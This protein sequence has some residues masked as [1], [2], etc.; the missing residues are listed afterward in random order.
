MLAQALKVELLV[1][2]IEIAHRLPAP[3]ANRKRG[4]PPPVIV[5]FDSRRKRG[6]DVSSDLFRI[7]LQAS[8][9]TDQSIRENSKYD[10]RNRWL[11][12]RDQPETFTL[13]YPRIWRDYHPLHVTDQLLMT[14]WR[15]QDRLGYGEFEYLELVL[16]QRL[17]LLRM[18]FS[19]CQFNVKDELTYQLEIAALARKDGWPQV[20]RNC[21]A[22]LA[23]FSFDKPPC[24]VLEEA[25]LHWAK[26]NREVAT[27]LLKSLLRRLEQDTRG[28]EEQ[29]VQ[30]SIA[31][32]LYG[33]WMVETKSENPQNIIDQYFLKALT[34]LEGSSSTLLSPADRPEA[35]P[36]KPNSTL[37][38]KWRDPTSRGV[39]SSAGTSTFFP[40]YP[41]GTKAPSGSSAV[42]TADEPEGAFLSWAPD[43]QEPL[44]RSTLPAYLSFYI[45][46]KV[47]FLPI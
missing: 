23:T 39:I 33:S 22:R 4:L 18:A 40:C 35:R 41:P 12:R 29:L 43:Y 25:R 34:H 13:D 31:L 47:P 7:S 37:V 6:I 24:I 45:P 15:E 11:E 28:G 16:A 8:D 32:H 1:D 36:L 5:R 46:S 10:T 27:A 9:V 38:S 42:L 2:N 30:R 44:T 17:V 21:L 3:R 26:G 19:M 14:R 20:A